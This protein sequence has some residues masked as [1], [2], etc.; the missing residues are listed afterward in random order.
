MLKK[1]IYTLIE[2]KDRELLG[3]TLFS[4]NLADA[5]YS[6]VIGKKNNLYRYSNYFKSGIFF[7]KGMGPNNYKDMIK[8]KKLGHKIVGYDEEGLVM[9][10]VETISKRVDSRCMKLVEFFFTVGKNQS[11]NTLKAY[12]EFNYKIKEIGNSRFDLLKK[13]VKNFFI[14]ET[15]KI[16]KKYGKFVFFPSKFTILNNQLYSGIPN[17]VK[18]GPGRRVLE[19][20]LADQIKIET[21]LKKFFNYFPKKYPNIKIVVKPHPIENKNYW[22]NL[23]K[24]INCKNFIL[25]DDK[26]LTNSYIISSEFNVGS[27]CHTSLESYLANK[28]TINLRPAN[29]DGLIISKLIRAISTV[30]ILDIKKLEK[31]IKDW[32]I[33]KKKFKIKLTKKQKKILNYNIENIKKNADYYF[34]KHI[35]KIVIKPKIKEDKYSN[36]FFLYFFETLRRLKNKYYNFIS[37]KKRRDYQKLKFSGLDQ[38]EFD[39]NIYKICKSLKKNYYNYKIKEIYPGCY[40]IEKKVE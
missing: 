30:E 10:Q 29:K 28:P 38:K 33:N 31:I 17:D 20:D 22:I 37:F 27:N 1:R 24:K 2:I 36:F 3:K 32:F 25:A 5:G 7:F 14:G 34:L 23:I 21:K 6:V 18:E 13:R 16:K 35:K 4:I 40:C 19:S 39:N 12:P 8:L 9:N 11:K 26:Y 15:D